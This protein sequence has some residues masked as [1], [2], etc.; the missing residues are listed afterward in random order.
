MCVQGVKSSC[1]DSNV[2]TDDACDAAKGCQ[3]TNN[4]ASCTD[5]SVCTVSDVCKNA[6]C[7]PGATTVCD[8][9]NP[10]TV[11]SCDAASGCIVANTSD[12]TSCKQ[13]SCSPDGNFDKGSLCKTG[14]CLPI[15]A[16][17]S[18]DDKNPCTDD[19]CTPSGGCGYTNNLAVCDDGNKCSAI[20]QCTGGGCIPGQ[21]VVCDDKNPCSDDKC[22]PK[23]GCIASNNTLPCDDGSV[24]SKA[25][26]CAE[27]ACSPGKA[28]E[29]DD[30]NACTD[31]FCDG[32]KGCTYNFNTK[33]CDDENACTDADTCDG[34]AACK[35][36]LTGKDCSDANPCTIDSCDTTGG[37][38]HKNAADGAACSSGLCGIDGFVGAAICATGKCGTAPAA[39]GCDDKNP[40]TTDLC[41][42]IGGCSSVPNTAGCDDGNACTKNDI[43]G[44]STCNG[45]NTV[46]GDN[47]PCTEDSCDGKVGCVFAAN[48]AVCDDANA[49]TTADICAASKC[50][51]GAAPDCDDKNGCTID[52]C[53]PFKGCVNQSTTDGC[54]DKNACTS[55]DVCGGGAC[56]GSTKVTCDDK[57]VCTT[58][59]CDQ[60]KGCGFAP[61]TAL[62]DDGNLCTDLDKCANAAC[63]GAIVKC[64]DKNGCT[65]D[66][67]DA[68]S[69]CVFTN[70]T[71]PCDDGN[72]CT[73]ADG[74]KNSACVGGPAPDCDDKKICTADSCDSLKGCVNANT[75]QPCDDGTLCTQ[76]DVCALG[77]CKPGAT[78]SCDDNNLC[79]DD[80]CEAATGCKKVFNQKP[81]D[82]GNACNSAD[83]CKNGV[84]AGIGGKDCNDGNPCTTD[85]CDANGGCTKVNLTNGAAC[86][87]SGCAGGSFQNAATCNSGVCS[88]L[89]QVTSCDDKNP[90]TTDFCDDIKGCK[91]VVNTAGCTDGNACTKSD[92]CSGGACAGVTVTC[93]DGNPC[94][95]DFCDSLAGCEFTNNFA[96]CD[97]NSLCTTN[98]KCAAGACKGGIAPNCDDNKPCTDDG[99]D[100]IKGCTHA[101]NTANCDDANACTTADKCSVGG[102]IGGAAPNCDDKNPCTNDACD[103]AI[104]CTSVGNTAPC[105]D[106]NACTT[107]D[108]CA[109]SA[110]KGGVAPNCDDKEACTTDTCDKVKGCVATAVADNTKCAGAN[111]ATLIFQ[112]QSLCAVGK[113]VKP[114]TQNCDDSLEC[115]VDTCSA[116]SG[117]AQ[118]N[119]SFG[120]ACTNA[121]VTY[122]FCINSLCTGVEK[123]SAQV[124]GSA[125]QF[126]S[127]TGIDR[128]ASGKINA[129]GI[130]TSLNNNNSRNGI[131]ANVVEAPNLGLQSNSSLG[132]QGSGINDVR[133]RLAVGGTSPGD[134]GA[135]AMIVNPATGFWA[136][137]SGPNVTSLERGLRAVDM[138]VPTV[139]SETYV[140]GGSAETGT[141]SDSTTNQIARMT[142]NGTAWSAMSRM[143]VSLSKAT[144]AV[145]LFNVSDVYAASATAVFLVGNYQA[146]S[147]NRTGVAFWDGNT[148]T[149]CGSTQGQSGVAHID[150]AVVSSLGVTINTS[151]VPGIG[152]F[153]AVHGSS[154]TNLLVGGA[155]GTLFGFDGS[156]W[157]QMTP[158]YTGIPVVWSN[159]FDVRGLWVTASDGWVTGTEDVV[160]GKTTCRRLFLL[161]GTV[162]TG[163]W[164]W[165]KQIVSTNND[166][167]VC[168]D[169]G[170]SVLGYMQTNRMWFDAVNGAVYVVG[171][172]GANNQ[173]QPTVNNPSRQFELVVRVKTKG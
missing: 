129:G 116:V 169:T 59:S 144:C 139:G 6:A 51:G 134:N 76:G 27:G 53:D 2:C 90:C 72:A 106:L 70:T 11:D 67:C 156:K 19:K 145:Q 50:T 55:G 3:K 1:D 73:T 12:G 33:P 113:C 105:D 123:V 126:G 107:A 99:C 172:R 86:S 140:S 44:N 49:C 112:P 16:S 137:A 159:Q 136:Q 68:T 25:D 35:G 42:P 167:A 10:C 114:A 23:T 65:T 95:D 64:D 37:C 166:L 20:D 161:H 162:K 43:C 57:N 15:E 158:N 110:C 153:R 8:D 157:T 82:D 151:T 125:V 80:S 46:C 122:P 60:A 128:V 45:E 108:T 38:V 152:N 154:A 101:N 97:D 173:G 96:T 124:S 142:W 146:G 149:T 81:C 9:A 28:I 103:K 21:A 118:V 5:N 141:P 47:N 132:V 91:S 164:T 87:A 92:I 13:P 171:S 93:N 94:T 127:L 155:A 121:A 62:C 165:D 135:Y 115:S 79:T 98:D 111:C 18:C 7:L 48:K 30:K 160:N 56:S 78:V 52:K 88:A 17:A 117:C 54:D 83:S 63:Q 85:S 147:V 120:T 102:C 109:A 143:T 150:A 14:V 100:A 131:V 104:G 34:N 75:T 84:C 74:C 163:V 119:K 77:A 24:C 29:C 58:D 170:D 41:S 31:E 89:P 36:S 138:Y 32:V 130:D 69:G 133:G 148:T 39:K 168:A 61:N 71:A 22:D 40:C 4:T 66:T 26:K